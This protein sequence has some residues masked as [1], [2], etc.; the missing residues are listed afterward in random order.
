MRVFC[1]HEDCFK[2]SGFWFTGALAACTRS[3]KLRIIAPKKMEALSG[4]CLQIPC[5]F[6]AEQEQDVDRSREIFGVW[7]KNDS[8]FQQVPSNV[9]FNSRLSA[10]T[11]P[12]SITGKLREKNCNILFSSLITSYTN[13]YYFRIETDS[14]KATAVCDPLQINVEGKRVLFLS[15]SS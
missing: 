3:S 12:M 7:I 8:R 2:L 13:T 6:R 4:S 15:V 9:I 10:N 1:L 11:Y 14:F 5:S